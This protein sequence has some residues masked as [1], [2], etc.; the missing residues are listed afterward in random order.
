MKTAPR[1]QSAMPSL[2]QAARPRRL[3]PLHHRVSPGAVDLQ[4]RLSAQEYCEQ[5]NLKAFLGGLAEQIIFHR[6]SDPVGY[7]AKE[8]TARA[9]QQTTSTDV[10]QDIPAGKDAHLF[11]VI[12]ESHTR[13]GNR[14]RKQ[15]SRIVPSGGAGA[16]KML[17]SAKRNAHQMVDEFCSPFP[18]K[19]EEEGL[20]RDSIAQAVG[21]QDQPSN[22]N[23]SA[24]ESMTGVG[25]CSVNND[26][27]PTA[28]LQPSVLRSL[29]HHIAA[30]PDSFFDEADADESRD[31]C[32]DEFQKACQVFAEGADQSVL[33]ALFVEFAGE[34]DKISQARFLEVAEEYRNVRHFVNKA[35]CMERLVD[36]LI[37]RVVE[38]RSRLP[39]EEG[40]KGRS[41]QVLDSIL[42]QVCEEGVPLQDIATAL[43]QQAEVLKAQAA[44]RA[45]ANSRAEEPTSGDEAHAEKRKCA[46]N[47]E[48]IYGGVEDFDRGYGLIGVPKPR[49]MEGM[50]SEWKEMA[51]SHDTF[52][53]WNS[54]KNETTPAVEYDFVVEPFEPET[55]S[56]HSPPSAWQ[57]K[58]KYGGGRTPLRLQ[59]LCHAVGARSG[60]TTFDN[61][62]QADTLDP[63]DPQWLHKEE[64]SDAGGT[65][66][67]AP[68]SC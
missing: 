41:Q 65:A 22:S 43:R 32:W 25:M 16:S 15:L 3:S 27:A 18:Q 55:V 17:N 6:P 1:H 7:L 42:A 50:R 67:C 8:L 30:D 23:I 68:A 14:K 38:K 9:E 45:E 59:V 19:D 51:D 44:A 46:D 58:H 20:A 47:P 66:S 35:E 64:V 29:R 26:A 60:Q 39:V 49:V 28:S 53:A 24:R 56:E 34:E 63:S 2:A 54:G 48:A 36:G 12:V 21:P 62:S 57:P 37:T 10:L 5:H 33:K 52:E 61:Y 11:R 31:L 13:S 40:A 4:D